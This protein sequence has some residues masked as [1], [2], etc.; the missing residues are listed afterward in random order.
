MPSTLRRRAILLPLAALLALAGCGSIGSNSPAP[1]ASG[2]NRPVK[3][4]G[5][6]RVALSAEPDKLDPTLARTLVGR[7]VFNAICEKLYDVDA[8]LDVVPQLAAALPEFSADGKTVTI[9][10]RTGVKFADGT[11]LD[12]AAVKTSLD[13][14]V[15]LA[16]SAR[17]SELTSVAGV[18]A[19]D[20]ATVTI[21]LKA[22]FVPLTAVLADRAGMVMSPTA[23]KAGN[24]KFA[25]NPVCVGPFKFSTRVAQDRIEVVKDPNYYD[26]AKVHL[27]K[28]VYRIIADA[29]T[30]LNNL[31]SGDVE[32]LDTVAATDV[33]TLKAD[34]NQKLL[35]S[36]SLGYQGIT[37]NLG[38]VA[39]VGKAAGS[40][41]APYAGPLAADPRV[42]RA[43]D[44]SL[45]RDAINKVVFRGQ[46]TPTCSPI[47]AASP[48]S[49]DAAQACPKHDAA[50]AKQL[51]QSAG[52]AMPVKVSMVLANTPDERRLGEAIQSQVKEGGFDLQLVPTEFSA[53]LDQTDAGK[54]Q[55]FRI[56]WS[57]RIDPDGN[58]AVFVQTKGSQNISGYASPAVDG[59][60]DQAR[61]TPDQ[62]KRKD[63]YGQL[64]TKLHEDEP[65]IYLYRQKNLT[66]VA[67]KVAGVQ[68]YGDGLIRL[69]GAGFVA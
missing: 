34:P 39:G 67:N 16:G 59:L 55:L 7:T 18:D 45:D 52:V 62:A 4:G 35:T 60:L 44:L 28:V 5:T 23:L 37:V 42:R 68:V 19:T 1:A 17:K 14:H 2:D 21:H 29:T 57:G 69:G 13:R 11:P 32:V 8:K 63:L 54:Y 40:L 10:V 61:A 38:N 65:L 31:R 24:D 3:N 48:L 46:F 43:F 15:S 6:L 12:A 9:K 49:S 58:L 41:A 22:P 20:P 47:S 53:S 33:D 25:T 30:R 50:A 64:I 51:L 26:A 36:D 27:D 56:G 66:G